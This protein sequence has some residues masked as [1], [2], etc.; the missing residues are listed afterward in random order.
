MQ[1]TTTSSFK[2]R[3]SS[4]QRRDFLRQRLHL[5]GQIADQCVQDLQ[6]TAF[7]LR[8]RCLVFRRLKQGARRIQRRW[9]NG[10]WNGKQ[11]CNVR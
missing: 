2:L 6:A 8:F 1:L 9:L 7:L 10:L 3:H 5:R 11:Q 4:L